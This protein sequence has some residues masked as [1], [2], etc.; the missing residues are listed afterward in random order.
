[1]AE[2]LQNP[3]NVPGNVTTGYQLQNTVLFASMTGFI[4]TNLTGNDVSA[5]TVFELNGALAR[6]FNNEAIFNLSSIPQSTIFYIYAEPVNNEE[7]Q[8]YARLTKPV[9]NNLKGG[10]YSTPTSNNRAIIKA[11]KNSSG[12]I[13][14]VKMNS[15]LTDVNSV[16]PPNSGGTQVINKTVRAHESYHGTPGWYR[17]EMQSGLGGGDGGY[18]GSGGAGGIPSVSNSL[19]GVFYH[20]GG[21]IIIH[22]GGNG[23]NGAAGTDYNG[24]T[25]GGGGG[26]GSGEETYIISGSQKFSTERILGGNGGNNGNVSID[27]NA[28]SAATLE[29]I[30]YKNVGTGGDTGHSS[31]LGGIFGS[32]G[33]GGSPVASSKYVGGKGGKPG[34]LRPF[35]DSAAGYCNLYKF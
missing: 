2:I 16:C 33:T 12:E 7:V 30:L 10:Y 13:E 27:I 15:I 4:N 14:A 11:I 32:G 17:F 8:F 19:T 5:G 18:S 35:N 28:G 26:G 34:W 22:V 9:W 31:F 25:T 1:M 21:V 20:S 29:S 24:G 23:F 6:C 3:D